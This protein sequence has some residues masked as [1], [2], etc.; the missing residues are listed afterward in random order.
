MPFGLA[1]FPRLSRAEGHAQL[2]AVREGWSSCLQIGR[3]AGQ[4]HV[5]ERVAV[6]DVCFQ[7]AGVDH[8]RRPVERDQL[9]RIDRRAD[10]LDLDSRARWAA[11]GVNRSRP[12]KVE[13]T[14][15]SRYW[16]LS[17]WWTRTM[18]PTLSAPGMSTPLSGRRGSRRARS[19]SRSVAEP[20][21]R[22]GRR[23]KRVL[24]PAGTAA[25]TTASARHVGCCISRP[26]G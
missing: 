24:R 22:R 20:S 26:R 10:L 17:I 21:R 6:D 5:A 7:A 12:W 23:R 3:E 18:P 1:T 19:R 13:L 9:I 15:G 25:R 2:V 16:A 4:L 11:A 8:H 14:T